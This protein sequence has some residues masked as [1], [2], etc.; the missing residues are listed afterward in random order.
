MS[1]D[2]HEEKPDPGTTRRAAV[3]AAASPV[4]RPWARRSL[5]P[6]A[7]PSVRWRR[8]QR[9]HRRASAT[10]GARLVRRLTCSWLVVVSLV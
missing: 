5:G 8:A 4:V 10:G 1:A 2:V 6:P 3:E 9:P 7:L